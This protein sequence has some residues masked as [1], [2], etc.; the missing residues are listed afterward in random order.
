M[1]EDKKCKQKKRHKGK[2]KKK[3]E[4]WVLKRCCKIQVSKFQVE[5]AYLSEFEA[6]LVYKARTVPQRKS[7]SKNQ[8]EMEMK[9]EGD[10]DRNTV[11]I[12]LEDGRYIYRVSV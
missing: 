2:K 3:T 10:R 8:R 1:T 5:Q 6:S 7:V 11:N 12:L 9:R 4:K